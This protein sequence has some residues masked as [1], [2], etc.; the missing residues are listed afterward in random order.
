M[1][2][3]DYIII[4]A[5]SSGCALAKGLTENATNTV[6]LLEAAPM[7]TGSGSTRL[8]AWPSF[9]SRCIELELLYRAY[10][11]AK[12]PQDVLASR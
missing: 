8:L 2:K 1:E 9:F 10:G 3:F 6:L 12:R 7:L 5:G 11:E 4:G